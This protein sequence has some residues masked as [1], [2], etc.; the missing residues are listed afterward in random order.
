[1]AT[2]TIQ[3]VKDEKKTLRIHLDESKKNEDEKKKI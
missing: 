3:Q 2:W 1:M